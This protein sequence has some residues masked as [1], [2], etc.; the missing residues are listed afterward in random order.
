MEIQENMSYMRQEQTIR[1]ME[2]RI[3][4]KDADRLLRHALTKLIGDDMQWLDAY[5]KVV[6]WLNDNDG[7]S[8]MICGKCGVGKSVIACD[9]IRLIIS[10][11]FGRNF[12]P[13]SAT[14]FSKLDLVPKER[15]LWIIDDLGT[16]R[17]VKDFGTEKDNISE[18]LDNLEMY[19]GCAVI[20]TNLNQEL[21]KERYGERNF[22]RVKSRFKIVSIDHKSMRTNGN[23]RRKQEDRQ[24]EPVVVQK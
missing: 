8:L 17:K 22:D 19:G 20:T 24:D 2:T 10:Y 9:A 12:P 7:K 5:D 11:R 18:L 23:I 14:K 16:E 6:G 13:M 21:F 1:R 15:W 4:V 3:V